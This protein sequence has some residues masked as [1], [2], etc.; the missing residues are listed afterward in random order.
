MQASL[1]KKN[2]KW[3]ELVYTCFNE[4][5]NDISKLIEDTDAEDTKRQNSV[6]CTCL[7]K[8]DISCLMNNSAKSNRVLWYFLKDECSIQVS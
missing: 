6:S 2:S 8:Y 7:K 4:K 3:Q 5:K 1:F